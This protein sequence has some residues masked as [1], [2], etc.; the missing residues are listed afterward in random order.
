MRATLRSPVREYCTPGSVRGAP[1]NRRPYLD[2]SQGGGRGGQRQL[3]TPDALH[4]AYQATEARASVIVHG[5]GW[6][7]SAGLQGSRRQG[8]SCLLVLCSGTASSSRLNRK[9]RIGESSFGPRAGLLLC[10][11]LRRIV[12]LMIAITRALAAEHQMFRVILTDIRGVLAN[13][14]GLG[15]V[16]RLA[17]LVEG[18][19]RVHGDVE[20]DLALFSGHN[21]PGQERPDD[22]CRREHREIDS[23]LT[24]VHTAKTPAEAKRLLCGAMAASRRHFS[25]EE[26]LF[27]PLL[28][29][30]VQ[31]D[32]LTAM[33]TAWFLQHHAPPKW[34]I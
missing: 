18:L 23:Q 22:R 14:S 6:A 20:D 17:R 24:R 9:H 10:S 1:G 7:Y 4:F 28:E 32:T 31:P 2:K 15:E 21:R 29:R 27:F 26:R 3:L 13:L 33:G 34:V 8:Y 30:M 5:N 11:W 19:L 16:K 12:H 25:H